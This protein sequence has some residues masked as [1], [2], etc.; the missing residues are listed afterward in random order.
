MGGTPKKDMHKEFE[1]T[2]GVISGCTPKRDIQE[3]LEDAKRSNRGPYTE[4]GY[5]RRA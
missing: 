4:E 2:K 5:T 3:E 1:D